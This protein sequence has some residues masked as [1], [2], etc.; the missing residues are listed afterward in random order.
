MNSHVPVAVLGRTGLSVTRLGIG[1][2]YCEAA[3]GQLDRLPGRGSCCVLR[4]SY[5][6]L[7]APFRQHAARSPDRVPLPGE[8]P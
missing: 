3:E 8:S 7:R 2:A 6:V 4:G 1:G 5:S